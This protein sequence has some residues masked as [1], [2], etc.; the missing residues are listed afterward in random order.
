MASEQTPATPGRLTRLTIRHSSAAVV[1]TVVFGTM[2]ITYG[3]LGLAALVNAGLAPLVPLREYLVADPRLV[4]C[5]LATSVV[6]VALLT[7]SRVEI[8][9]GLARDPIVDRPEAPTGIERYVRSF[10][11][12]VAV[13]AYTASIVVIGGMLTFEALQLSAVVGIGVLIG[14]PSLEHYAVVHSAAAPADDV[15][16]FVTPAFLGAALIAGVMLIAVAPVALGLR[17]VGLVPSSRRYLPSLDLLV[18]S[19]RSIQSRLDRVDHAGSTF[20]HP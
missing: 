17:L 10:Y 9:A 14:Y 18:G 7:A 5:V 13:S 3:Y 16:A 11:S 2:G 20:S 15:G 19:I 4:A 6:Y 1:E 8:D 12:L